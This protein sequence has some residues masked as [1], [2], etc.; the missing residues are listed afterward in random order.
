[1]S[2]TS[3]KTILIWDSGGDYVHTA[4]AI[5]PEYGR[6]LYYCPWES[7]FSTSKGLL[8]GIGIDGIERVPDF[9][10]SLSDADIVMFTDVGN[11][12]LTEYLRSQGIPVFG[13]G[14]GG[15]LETD[16]GFLKQVCKAHGID[17]AEY[18]E[19]HGIDNLRTILERNEDLYVKLSYMRGEAETRHHK[20]WMESEDWLNALAV[21]MG[22]YKHL[23]QFIVEMPISDDDG[24]C[25]E[26]G[27]DSFCSDGAFPDETLYGYEAKDSAYL[28]V[29]GALPPRLLET[30]SRLEPILRSVGYR[31][32]L[33]TE[34]RETE[35][36]SYLVDLTCFS[37]DTEILTDKGWK[38]FYDLD[39]TEQVATLDV[40]TREIVYQHPTAYQ[41]FD[42]DGEMW[43]FSSPRGVI[44]LR[45]TPDHGFWVSRRDPKGT[46]CYSKARDLKDKLFMPRT[47][48]WRGK[49]PQTFPL[50]MYERR[51]ESFCGP[52][53]ASHV[54]RL[55]SEPMLDIPMEAWLRFL[56]VYLAEGSVK[57]SGQVNISQFKHVGQF[58]DWLRPLP[59]KVSVYDGGLQINSVQLAQYLMQFGKCNEK[60]VPEFV[61]Q[62]SSRLINVFLE[63]FGLG[64]GHAREGSGQM[65]YHTT[66]KRLA[67]DLQELV[68]KAGRVASI[69][70]VSTQ[71]TWAVFKE[72]A[73]PRRYDLYTVQERPTFDS[74]YFEASGQRAG[75]YITKDHYSG[76]V[77]DVTVPN[78]T[79][80]VRRA[81]KPVWT[82][83][84]R[85]PSP[86]SEL[87]SKL[88]ANLGE[89]IW[90]VARGEVATPE[91]RFKYGAQIV[92]RSQE[93][94][95]H[96]VALKIG[97]P[98]RT[99][100]HGHCIVNG[101]DY[102]VS[103]SE[104]PE[105]GGVVGMGNSMEDAVREAYEVAES[106]EGADIKYDSGALNKILETIEDG[107]EL[108]ISWSGDL[109]GEESGQR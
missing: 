82:S 9:W 4:E 96:H 3:D 71:N 90:Q 83:N 63:A 76:M 80:Y 74:Y 14:A 95:E 35:S 60:F 40:A 1:M 52:N 23:A 67:D 36:G 27:F 101:Q 28:G 97:R 43:R 45:V 44:D 107:R 16:R 87:E 34:T 5:I 89:V 2:E 13:S 38:R 94:E 109:Y 99:A 47:G 54:K 22:P 10:E 88:I 51:W 78:G 86:P 59:W 105:M 50:P 31:G 98:D 49:E 42:Y 102:A 46:L 103:V 56:G 8:V 25:V 62:L 15:K 81:G 85:W 70:T 26:I 93:F 106:V 18:G 79:I 77:Y 30:R 33:S 65:R 53:N 72:G 108:G 69:A 12:G 20:N 61:K 17:A 37:S 6:V 64:D 11:Y 104:I 68:F 39:R 21:R 75:D 84:C 58:V 91:Y 48:I 32:P 55:K 24:P 41:A 73:Y 7:A 92:L 19:V 57:A 66:S 100:I 29:V